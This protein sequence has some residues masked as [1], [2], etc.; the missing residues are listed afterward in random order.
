MKQIACSQMGGPAT[1]TTVLTGNTP[2]EMVKNGMEHVKAQH[3]EIAAQIAAMS[4]EDTEKWMADFT[5]KF[6]TLMDA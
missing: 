5:A 3:P 2:E 1:C 6:P 4:K